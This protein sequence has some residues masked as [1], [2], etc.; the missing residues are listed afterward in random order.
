MK[1]TAIMSYFIKQIRRERKLE[2]IE[3]LF[4]LLTI[5]TTRTIQHIFSV[6]AS[7]KLVYIYH[8]SFRNVSS[9]SHHKK[10]STFKEG[11]FCGFYWRSK[12]KEEIVLQSLIDMAMAFR[13]AVHNYMVFNMNGQYNCISSQLH[14]SDYFPC[15]NRPALRY[16]LL[17]LFP[18]WTVYSK[19]QIIVFFLTIVCQHQF[20]FNR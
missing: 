10:V 2:K 13:H 1:L 15:S 9:N 4:S 18:L 19:V 3:L 7:I 11:S 20:D 12:C 6:I 5:H 16:H 8:Y 17:S 14:W